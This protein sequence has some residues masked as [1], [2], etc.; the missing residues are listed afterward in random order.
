MTKKQAARMMRSVCVCVPLC[1][2]F[3]GKPTGPL[4]TCGV[5][6]DSGLEA[7]LEALFLQADRS[8]F[9]ETTCLGTTTRQKRVIFFG[10]AQK[11]DETWTKR[12]ELKE[13]KEGLLW[14]SSPVSP[15][16]WQY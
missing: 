14:V 12:G 3:Q 6:L 9:L 8:A 15:E 7:C 2:W 13:S 10:G 11:K 16:P 5:R 1:T 4:P